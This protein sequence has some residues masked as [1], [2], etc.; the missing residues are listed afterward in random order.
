M[1][2]KVDIG[3]PPAPVSEPPEQGK[4]HQFD[5]TA[6]M[7]L[8]VGASSGSGRFLP[9]MARKLGGRAPAGLRIQAAACLLL[10]VVFKLNAIASIG[11]ALALLIFMLFTAAHFRVRAEPGARTAKLALAIAAVG[12]VDVARHLGDKRHPRLSDGN[13]CMPGGRER[14]SSRT[15]YNPADHPGQHLTIL[16]EA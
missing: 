1:T 14:S 9:L 13:T 3:E 10:I 7:A 16:P 15:R 2:R 5:L 6:S 4:P 11:T 12:A 8:I